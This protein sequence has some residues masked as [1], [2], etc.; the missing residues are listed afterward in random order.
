MKPLLRTNR[1]IFVVSLAALVVSQAAVFNAHAEAPAALRQEAV[2]LHNRAR[3][4]DENAAP[5]AVERLERHC[6]QFP[7]DGAAWAYLGSAY[8]M[9]GRD[10]PAVADKVR[11]TN[12]GI[13]HLDRAL[14]IA[15]QDFTVR[16][17]RANVNA[18]LPQMFGRGDQATEDMLALDRMFRGAEASPARAGMMLGIYE[19]LQA[20]A[21]GR[22]PWA[23][24]LQEARAM[25]GR[26]E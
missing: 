21:P 3:D 12:R 7:E 8:T 20:R 24:R 26:E 6:K 17:V 19:A 10:A 1:R 14:E 2:E 15:P 4:G 18:A 25:A 22:G 13:R 23:E 5:Q 16:L 11:Y 9:M